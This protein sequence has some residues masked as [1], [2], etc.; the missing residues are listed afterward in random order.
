MAI[1][2]KAMDAAQ[3]LNDTLTWLLENHDAYMLHSSNIPLF[4][5]SGAE[6]LACVGR[7]SGGRTF[8]GGAGTSYVRLVGVTYHFDVCLEV[9][10]GW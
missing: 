6:P 5:D 7:R 2:S 8:E 3:V 4:R 1:I 10:R 9:T